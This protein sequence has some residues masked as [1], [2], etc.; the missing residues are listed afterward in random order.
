MRAGAFALTLDIRLAEALAAN[1]ADEVA[2]N[3]ESDR[4]VSRHGAANTALLGGFERGVIVKDHGMDSGAV[5]VHILPSR[6]A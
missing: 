6:L 4:L 1:P 3:P 5:G 2:L